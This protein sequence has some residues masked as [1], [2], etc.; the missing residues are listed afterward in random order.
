MRYIIALLVEMAIA[1]AR[2]TATGALIGIIWMAYAMQFT[3]D[4][5]TLFTIVLCAFPAG[6]LVEVSRRIFNRK[7]V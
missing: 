5:L 1:Y 2:A 7:D 4:E 6:I 3:T